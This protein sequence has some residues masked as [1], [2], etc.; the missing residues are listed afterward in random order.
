MRTLADFLRTTPGLDAADT[1]WL[2]LLVEDWQLLADLL[3]SDLVLWVED[4]E[5]KG[6]IG[7]GAVDAKMQNRP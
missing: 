2:H 5:E 1:E 3:F 4:A 7:E 6:P